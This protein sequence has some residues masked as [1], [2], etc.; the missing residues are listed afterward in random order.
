MHS[1]WTA[2]PTAGPNPRPRHRA[3]LS[4]DFMTCSSAV[5][6]V[7]IVVEGRYTVQHEHENWARLLTFETKFASSDE[8]VFCWQWRFHWI[9]KRNLH[10]AK[11]NNLPK[12]H[13]AGHP[14]GGGPMQ[15]HRLN[16]LK[17]G[18]GT[19]TLWVSNEEIHRSGLHNSESSQDQIDQHKFAGCKCLFRCSVEAFLK[20]N[21]L[22]DVRLLQYFLQVR[23]L[24]SAACLLWAAFFAGL[25]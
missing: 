9:L 18:P 6:R 22:S 1:T 3:P 2:I 15:L 5:N 23:K 17:A 25:V 12:H 13:G 4:S 7:T 24:L 16:R 21:Y 8:S 14:D 10:L 11:M 19:I 20:Y